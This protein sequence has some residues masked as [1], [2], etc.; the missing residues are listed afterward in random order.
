MKEFEITAT[1]DSSYDVTKVIIAKDEYHAITDCRQLI[2][3][4][5]SPKT[6]WFTNIKK[7]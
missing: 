2:K 3:K 7:L 5:Y 6:I 4:E 1:L